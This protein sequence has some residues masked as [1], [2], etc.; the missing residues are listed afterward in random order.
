LSMEVVGDL[1]LYV[2]GHDAQKALLHQANVV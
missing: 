1:P 2:V